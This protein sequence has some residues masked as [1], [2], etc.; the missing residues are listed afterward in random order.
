MILILIRG[1]T[2]DQ[3]SPARTVLIL[4][5]DVDVPENALMIC[6]SPTTSM[7]FIRLINHVVINL[8]H[9]DLYCILTLNSVSQ[10]SKCVQLQYLI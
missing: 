7:L 2:Y 6:G 5:V 3:H 8:I 10:H 9:E 1:V 4:P